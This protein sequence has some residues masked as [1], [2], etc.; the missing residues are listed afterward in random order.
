M[1]GTCLRVCEE[2][3]SSVI[4]TCG[5]GVELGHAVTFCS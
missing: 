1:I 5:V 2:D 3:V 4:G